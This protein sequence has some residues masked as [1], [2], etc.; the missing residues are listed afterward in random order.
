MGNLTVRNCSFMSK[1]AAPIKVEN[2]INEVAPC[3][4]VTVPW[5][6][7]KQKIQEN[8]QKNENSENPCLLNR[9]RQIPSKYSKQKQIENSISFF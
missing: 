4:Q 9:S 7:S 6:P 3:D 1:Q 2:P 8:P 5:K